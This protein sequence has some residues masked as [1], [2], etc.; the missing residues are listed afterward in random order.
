MI[1]ENG[2]L[3]EEQATSMMKLAGFTF[4]KVYE[5][6]SGY[7]PKAYN[8]APTGSW[9]LFLT[10]YGPVTLGCRKRVMEIDWSGTG[11]RIDLERHES[12]KW[13]TIGD[14]YAHVY[15]I[16]TAIR[17]LTI[18]RNKLKSLTEPPK[19]EFPS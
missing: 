18:I 15:D 8:P 13:I 5:L 6:V 10:P 4:T 17:D 11:E 16:P 1:Y 2:G 9:W 14:T 19:L 7:W 3:S 12:E